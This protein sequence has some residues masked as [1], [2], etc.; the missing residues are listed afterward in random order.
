M[1]SDI[2]SWETHWFQLKDNFLVE[3]K[4]DLL[5]ELIAK[6][7]NK[8]G[9][10]NL[11]SKE[12]T[13]T[14]PT[15]YNFINKEKHKMISVLKLKRLLKYLDI[16]FS[17]INNKVKLTKKGSVISIE[18]PR[19]PILLNT[20]EGAYLLGLIVSD[21][22]IYRDGKAGNQLRTKYAAGEAES[23]N[24]FVNIINTIYGNVH[25]QREFARNCAMLRIGTSIIGESLVKVG[26]I[27]GNKASVDAEVPWLILKGDKKLK[28]SYL[29]AAFGDE[30]SVYKEKKRDCGY[31]ILSRYRHLPLLNQ[32]QEQEL[33]SLEKYMLSHEFPTGHINKTM[34]LKKAREIIKDQQL[35]EELYKA[36]KLLQ[37]ES[38]MLTGLGINNRLFGRYLTKTHRGR[39]SLCFDLFINQ[40]DSLKKFY[41]EIGFSLSRKQQKL[42]QLIG[43]ENALKSI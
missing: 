23:E 34:P 14:A 35:I 1:K 38:K 32:K 4:E 42:V 29:K 21:G 3:L 20:I 12:L 18:N 33:Q 24:I 36:P 25:I 37:G 10:L 6:G 19:F 17:Y 16:D 13:L 27:I 39:Y 5:S 31:I 30:S 15:F 11:L 41:K 8:A 40:K 22:C 43:G 28:T 9:N 7:M 2:P 26:G